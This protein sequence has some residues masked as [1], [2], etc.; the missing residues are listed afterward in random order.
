MT[1]W[2]RVG[3]HRGSSA[4]VPFLHIAVLT[5]IQGIT[6]FLPVS[7]S[8]HL[9]LVP[10]VTGWQDQGLVMDV[11]VH[12]GTLAAVLVYFWRDLL[13]I[14]LGFVGGHW[15]RRD[16]RLGRALFGYLVVSAIPVIVA[17]GLLYL[18]APTALR[19]PAVVA[20]ATIGF[21]VL[22][23]A[24]DRGGLTVREVEHMSLGHAFFIG[25]FQVLALVPG[26]SRSGVTM[27]AAR[28]LG[29]ERPAAARFAMLMSIPVIAASGTVAGLEVA[30][31]GDPIITHDA[32]LAAVL[33]F[34]VALL[35]IAVLLALLRRVSFTPFVIYRLLLGGAVLIWLYYPA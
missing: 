25:V 33:S 5:I 12:V 27:T 18:L 10:V 23:Y 26:A 8:G 35:A 22:L 24:A 3:R 14:V 32:V 16:R 19:D 17:G 20:W 9:V 31:R 4:A 11:A 34:A 30:R 6:E 28:L 15:R 2:W 13:Q 21:G 29:Y 1:A 7:S